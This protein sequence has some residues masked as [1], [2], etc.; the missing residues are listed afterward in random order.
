MEIGNYGYIYKTTNLING[1][2]YIG[3]KTGEFNSD[4]FGSGV[5][6]KRAIKKYG[7]E[8]FRIRVLAYA[9]NLEMLDSL[10]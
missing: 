4:Y 3:L 2:I 5:L 8:N 1:R 7:K 10:K 6:I 9:N